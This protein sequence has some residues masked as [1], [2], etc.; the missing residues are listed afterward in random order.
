VNTKGSWTDRPDAT[1]RIPNLFLA[2]DYVRTY[3]DLA[4]MEGANE[5]ARRAVNGI[6]DATHSNA[7]RCDVWPLREPPALKH[8]RTFDR[9]LWRLRRPAPSPLRV[10]ATGEVEPMG[11]VGRALSLLRR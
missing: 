9:L 3:T 8:A 10:R 11:V 1:T 4:T 6:L 7:R 5:A 2:A